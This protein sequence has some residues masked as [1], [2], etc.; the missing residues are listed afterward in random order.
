MGMAASISAL[1]LSED[2]RAI[3]A[4]RLG[5]YGWRPD[6]AFNNNL[7]RAQCAAHPS[8]IIGTLGSPV[9]ENAGHKQAL[10][11]VSRQGRGATGMTRVQDSAGSMTVT[12]GM[13]MMVEEGIP[14]V[15]Y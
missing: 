11:T 8:G 12:P 1:L 9:N 5:R 3:S 14:E 15:I 13:R 2:I 6:H 4:T 7:R 10:Y